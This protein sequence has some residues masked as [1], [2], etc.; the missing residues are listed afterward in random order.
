MSGVIQDLAL[1]D[2]RFTKDH[3]LQ[4]LHSLRVRFRNKF[5][6]QEERLDEIMNEL[7]VLFTSSAS[8]QP[9]RRRGARMPRMRAAAQIGLHIQCPGCNSFCN[10][11]MGHAAVQV[12]ARARQ[13][14]WAGRCHGTVCCCCCCS[15]RSSASQLIRRESTVPVDPYCHFP[16]LCGV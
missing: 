11:N 4:I 14:G 12:R 6:Q 2:E 1:T 13:V 5:Q 9:R 10:M 7:Y 16:G 3:V 8:R 15:W